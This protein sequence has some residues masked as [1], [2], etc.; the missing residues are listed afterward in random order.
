MRIAFWIS[1][2]FIAY[3]YIG[4]PLCL[5]LRSRWRAPSP[6][7][8]P[9]S[10][11]DADLPLVSIVIAAHNEAE[12]LPHKLRN[13]AGL[14]YP[15]DRYEI[16]VVSDGSTD[17]T[18]P[19]MQTQANDRLRFFALPEHAGKA[20]ALNRA[21]EAAQGEI[22]IFT[23]ARQII[24]PDALR[25][26]VANFADPAVGCVSGELILGD[27]RAGAAG[28]GLGFYWRLEKKIRG[29]EAASGSV[30][31]ATGALYAMRKDLF[32]PLPAGTLLDDVYLPLHVVRQGKRVLFESRA[33]AYDNLANPQ[34]E[35]RR[36]VR[37]LTGNYQLL[38]LAPWL[39]TER[40]PVRIRFISHK[41]FRLWVPFALAVL[42]MA[43]AFLKS[44]FYQAALIA[45]LVFY[46][47]SI[48]AVWRTKLGL[49]T[50]LADVSLAFVLMNT[51]AAVALV[52]FLAGKKEIWARS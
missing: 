33:H 39:L 50:R 38:R 25:Y 4:Y 43:S 23:D 17:A 7:P 24:D 45:Q 27:A 48:L 35:F 2:L 40:S 19:W 44:T 10:G 1:A 49:I 51:A 8:Q 41:L 3:T 21:L 34:R 42:F 46:G 5:F 37:T 47:L 30:V 6:S 15:R 13:L 18:D 22:I 9:A 31:G 12:T 36:K 14:D 26:L 52:W 11:H 28:K 29:W 20:I 16:I 32:V